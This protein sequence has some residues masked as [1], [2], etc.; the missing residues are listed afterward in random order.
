MKRPN[1]AG[2]VRKLGGKRRKPWAAVITTGWD[3]ETGKRKQKYVGYYETYREAEDALILYRLDPMP[4]E[5]ATLGSVYREWLATKGNVSKS[6]KYGYDMAW[7]TLSRL[8]N[9]KIKDIRTGQLQRLI[10]T[11]TKEDG[12]SYSSGS[13]SRIKTVI[14]MIWDYAVKNDLAPKN[15]AKFIT[16]P[17][18]KRREKDRFTAIEVQQIKDAAAAGVPWADAVLMMIYTG[19][20]ISEFLSLDRFTV[21]LEHMTFRA[22]VKTDAGRNRLVP[23]HPCIL[24]YVRSRLAQGGERLIC[25]ADGSPFSMVGFRRACYYP[26]LERTGVRLL[27]PHC[28]R[29]T[30]A[31]MLA[32]ARVPAV[33]VQ[34]LLGHA[35]YSTTANTYTHLDVDA[36]RDAV[37]SL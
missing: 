30:F 26:A 35:Q 1:G 16:L 10:D 9:V 6:A 8:E 14:V 24:P 37:G 22:G 36:L 21:D 27:N 3:P 7:R 19:F 17:R 11:A 5:D 4:A 29:H 34:K 13:L 28:T 2:T 33:E 18:N 31:T 32:E 20:R 23:I 25:K 15:Y 12:A